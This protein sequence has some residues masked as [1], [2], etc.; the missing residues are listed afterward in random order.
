MKYQ[1]VP[2]L[3]GETA[4]MAKDMLEEVMAKITYPNV[5]EQYARKRIAWEN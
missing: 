5:R 1:T 3:D 4:T 2:S